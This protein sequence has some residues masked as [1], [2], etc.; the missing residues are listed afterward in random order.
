MHQEYIAKQERARNMV[1][2]RQQ[3]SMVTGPEARILA[4][5]ASFPTSL[6]SSW[7]VPRDICLPGL[8]EY[9]GVVRSALNVPLNELIDKK[10]VI[11]RKAHVIDGG[12][13]RRNIYHAT[14]LG[15]SECESIDVPDKKKVGELLGHPPAKSILRGR[16][17]IVQQLKNE[18][19][20]II[21]GLP[22]IGKTSILRK[23]ADELVAD[24]KTVRF[25]SMESFKDIIEIFSDW[26]LEYTS[27]SAVLNSTKNEVLI[28][29]EVQ[30]VSLR[31]LGR[32]EMF[33]SKSEN[34]IMASRAPLLISE[35]FVISEIPPLDIED[36]VGLLPVHLEN[37]QLVAER[38]GCHPL[39]LQMHDEKSDLPEAGSD[40]QEWVREVVLAELGDEIKA[41]DELSLLP[42][43]V[44]TEL[45][46]HEEY[47]LDLDDHALVRWFESGVELHHL[48]RNVR[49]TML[50][51][52]DHALAA[53]YWSEKEGDLARLIEMHQ[54]LKSGKDIESYLLSNTEGLMI[55][56][57]AGLATLIGDAINRYPTKTLHRVAAMVAIERGETE[58]ASEHLANCDT[59][60][61]EHSLSLLEGKPETIDFSDADTRLI[62][63]EAARRM[64]DRIPGQNPVGGILELLEMVD[65]SQ[66]EPEMKKIM[67]VTIAHIRHAWFISQSNWAE[68]TKIRDNLESISHVDDPQLKALKIRAEIAE[69]VP[70][71]PAFEKVVENVFSKIGLKATMLQISLVQRCDGERAVTLLK[72]IEIPSTEAQNNLSAA[73][74][75]AAKI[76]FLRA[77]YNTHNPFSAMSES[78][79][80]WKQ[81]LC[82]LAAKQA[83]ETMHKLL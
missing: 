69:T 55:R 44:P 73:R 46:Q 14:D 51:E 28:L 1:N 25:A 66:V 39:A 13:R 59:P 10:F 81:S 58:I 67:L 21:T 61:L 74:R 17:S 79:A 3:T 48:V 31:H 8:S 16:D 33:A 71:T 34:L 57:S 15:R 80:L 83:A 47:L 42:V 6:E 27:E 50:S 54:I 64:D 32:L 18:K 5:L 38:L 75:I 26:G 2:E 52:K 77:S 65:I 22:G 45:L 35:G 63:S 19:K 72:R 37:K 20:L 82:P 24:G 70:G 53:K 68:A 23:I 11:V 30:E 4:R 41:L 12:S 56:S 7:D 36:A 9:L 29:D 62:L 76:W 43:P 40:L 49:S 60:D 78:I